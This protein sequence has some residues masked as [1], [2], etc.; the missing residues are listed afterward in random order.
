MRLTSSSSHAT[1]NS[2]TLTIG[3]LSDTFSVTTLDDTTPNAFTFTDQTGVALSA[4]TDSNA[5]TVADITAP[6]AISITGGE[7]A[8]NGGAYL[9]SNSTVSNGDTVVVRVA[10]SASYSTAANAMLTIGGVS[11]T[12]T[13]TT[14]AVGETPAISDANNRSSF[15]CT[16]SPASSR[17]GVDPTLPLMLLVAGYYAARRRKADDT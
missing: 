5:I 15:G 7:Y 8:I 11:D 3:T 4:V 2:A 14:V 10:A 9:S 17:G 13:V 12:F 1:T 16:V 6:V